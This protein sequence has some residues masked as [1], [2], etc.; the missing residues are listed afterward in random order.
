M[1][2]ILLSSLLAFSF[3]AIAIAQT[4]TPEVDAREKNQ[5]ARIKEGVK[6]GE[7]TK[8]EAARARAEQQRIKNAEAKAKSDGVV[9][10][11]ERA[12]LDAKQDKASAHIYNQKHDAQ[13][14]NPPTPVVD[15]RE[16]A[17]HDRIKDGVKSGELTKAEATK[18]RADQ[19]SIKR[20]ETRAKADGVV[21]A[22]ESAKLDAKQDRASKRIYKNKHDAQKRN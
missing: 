11:A 14:R 12:K 16:K 2:K 5:H 17:Q 9:T 7:L 13:D 3:A 4:A 10:D 20:A 22:G 6:S 8:P 21:T 18:A 1:K 19:A 15:A